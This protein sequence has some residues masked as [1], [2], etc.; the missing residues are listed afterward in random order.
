MK[1]SLFSGISESYSHACI[2]CFVSYSTHCKPSPI[3][4]TCLDYDDIL[5]PFK[6]ETKVVLGRIRLTT[7]WN[8]HQRETMVPERHDVSVIVL[9]F[10]TFDYDPWLSYVSGRRLDR[11]RYE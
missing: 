2:V 7:E 6:L 1:I 10:H 3:Y 11:S 5:I 9:H 4:P 8:R